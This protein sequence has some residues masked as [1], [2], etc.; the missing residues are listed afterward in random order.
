MAADKKE[1]DPFDHLRTLK[2]YSNVIPSESIHSDSPD[3][4]Y[5]VR[6]GWFLATA[7]TM[8]VIFRNQLIEDPKLAKLYEGWRRWLNLFYYNNRLTRP[9]EIDIT[10]KV[11]DRILSSRE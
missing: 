4:R 11:I 3:N 6:K 1:W 2:G 8:E 9:R 7:Y 10:D 5:K